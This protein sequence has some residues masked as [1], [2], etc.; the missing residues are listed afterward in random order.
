MRYIRDAYY[1]IRSKVVGFVLPRRSPNVHLGNGFSITNSV[2]NYRGG[3]LT[4]GD[5]FFMNRNSSINC[6]Y[7]VTI[8]K[9]CLIGENVHIYD[10]N[11]VFKELDTPVAAQGFSCKEVVIG[12]YCWICTDVTILGG[13]H[14]GNN[15]IIGAGCL[16][17]RDIPD[18]TIVKS[19]Q[20]LIME[21]RSSDA[22]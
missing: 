8:G 5:R 18:N 10:H 20:D 16:I 1:K 13:V 19:R 9:A 14:I 3:E 7:K 11:H 21:Q 22:T 4:I 12:D 17:Y 6:H 15:C 2:I